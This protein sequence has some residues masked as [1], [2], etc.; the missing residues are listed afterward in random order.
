MCEARDVWWCEG[1]IVWDGV[2]W[3]V[4]WCEECIV[5]DGVLW[6]VWRY[7]GVDV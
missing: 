6:D 5:W 1:C 7:E 3:D 2:L 4:W